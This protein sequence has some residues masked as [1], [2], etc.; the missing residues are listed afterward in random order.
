MDTQSVRNADATD[1]R[2]RWTPSKAQDG[3][4]RQMLHTMPAGSCVYT[5]QL[6][7]NKN[8]GAWHSRVEVRPVGKIV[9][10]SRAEALAAAESALATHYLYAPD[11]PA[12]VSYA[13]HEVPAD[14][15]PVNGWATEWDVTEA[16]TW[17]GIIK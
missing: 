16:Y 3:L 2:A 6:L 15:H 7:I 13:C 4:A 12:T 9:V 11:V 10:R 8:R 1:M 17:V 5:I 14:A